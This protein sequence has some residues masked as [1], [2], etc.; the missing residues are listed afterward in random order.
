MLRDGTPVVIKHVSPEGLVPKMT[1]RP[2]A[3]F[4]LWNSG[5]FERMPQVIDHTMLGVE[6]KDDGWVVVMVDRSDA[7]LGDVQ[8]LTRDE[9]RFVLGAMNE[10]YREF[11]GEMPDG[12]CSLEQY[13]D[14]FLS[15]GG[16]QAAS[17]EPI[18]KLFIRG[19]EL[20]P[21]VAPP[22]V[23]EAMD[24]IHRDPGALAQQLIKRDSAFIHGD[25]RL[26]NLGLS[27]DRVVLLDWELASYGPPAVD[28]AW[29]LIISATRI[30][31]TR[32]QITDDFRTIS[33]DDFDPVALELAMT[34]ALAQL[35]WNKALD[36]VENPNP[37]I[38]EQERADL[39]WWIARVRRSLETWSPI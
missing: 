22:D 23:A 10:M 34:T 33:G 37:A 2:D 31:A 38:R 27:P 3:F 9:N 36:I 21:D 35:G 1:G 29:Y 24:A 12:A 15:W 28:F 25:L 7:F 17:E 20:F 11:R 30:D 6:P 8:V 18:I 13:F 4:R 32:E 16:L 26:H 5:V 19:W 39:D 14:V